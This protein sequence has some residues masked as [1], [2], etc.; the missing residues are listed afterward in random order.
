VVDIYIGK[1]PEK[2]DNSSDI[3]HR[4]CNKSLTFASLFL[5]LG[6]VMS[7]CLLNL[8]KYVVLS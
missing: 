8:N 2:Y 6:T 5:K 3:L 4:K 7:F 1:N